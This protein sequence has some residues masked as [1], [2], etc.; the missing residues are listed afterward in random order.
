M[1]LDSRSVAGVAM[2][3]NA[4]QANVYSG[5][6]LTTTGQQSSA[7]IAQSIGGGGGN[8]GVGTTQVSSSQVAIR[9]D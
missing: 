7:I 8:G 2:G 9:M 3:G 4:N 6:T 5:G 1:A